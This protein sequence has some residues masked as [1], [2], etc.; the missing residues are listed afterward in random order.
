MG[1]MLALG[2]SALFNLLSPDFKMIFSSGSI[3]MAFTCP[4]LIG[5]VFGFL[6]ASNAAKLDPIEALARD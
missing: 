2:L 3:I 5:V 6:P 4:T 1:V